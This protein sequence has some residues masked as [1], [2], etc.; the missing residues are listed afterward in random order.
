MNN[1]KNSMISFLAMLLFVG[2]QLCCCGT[3]SK[4]E[5]PLKTS[6]KTEPKT[7]KFEVKGMSCA[8]CTNHISEA[9]K[10]VNG[11][12]EQSVEYPGSIATI[13]YDPSKT[14]EKELMAAIEN[15]GYKVSN[16]DLK[17]DKAKTGRK[18]GACC[19]KSS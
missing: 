6:I 16:A 19:V 12:I 4:A 1:M 2:T 3:F 11:V 7:V 13:K 9:L 8:G 14:N 5:T 10:K 18:S 15:A 17:G